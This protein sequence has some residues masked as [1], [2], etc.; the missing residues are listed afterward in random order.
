MFFFIKSI[1]SIYRVV[2][3]YEV[4]VKRVYAVGDLGKNKVPDRIEERQCHH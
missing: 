1:T 3:K 2:G 4:D